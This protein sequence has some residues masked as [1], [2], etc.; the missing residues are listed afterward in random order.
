MV[1]RCSP[2][3]HFPFD[4]GTFLLPYLPKFY[5]CDLDIRGPPF[6][7]LNNLTFEGLIAR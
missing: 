5:L 1:Q 3:F 7:S 4:R 2:T 6:R